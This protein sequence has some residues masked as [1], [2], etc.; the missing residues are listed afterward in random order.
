MNCILLTALVLSC[1]TLKNSTIDA[2]KTTADVEA[3]ARAYDPKISQD[4]EE[5]RIKPTE[6][7]ASEMDCNGRFQTWC[8]KNWEKADLNNNRYTDLLVIGHWYGTGPLVVLDLGKDRFK[9]I[10]LK[11]QALK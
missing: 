6:E 11:G 10:R 4:P 7:L 2:L 3:F 5:F 9:F 1:I 8:I